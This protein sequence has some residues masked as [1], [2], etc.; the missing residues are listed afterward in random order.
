MTNCVVFFSSSL[1]AQQSLKPCTNW[2]FV[3]Q[4]VRF[5]NVKNARATHE[6]RRSSIVGVKM[7]LTSVRSISPMNERG[8]QKAALTYRGHEP[9]ESYS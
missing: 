8:S 6:A 2:P 5:E 4:S 3:I 7:R 9:M 1:T